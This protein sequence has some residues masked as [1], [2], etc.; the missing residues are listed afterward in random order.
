MEIPSSPSSH[1]FH[2]SVLLLAAE[3]IFGMPEG[4]EQHDSMMRIMRSDRNVLRE[5]FLGNDL[6]GGEGDIKGFHAPSIS[7]MA[8]SRRTWSSERKK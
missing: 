5:S 6:Q 1:R 7:I 3:D 8:C 4:G 2:F